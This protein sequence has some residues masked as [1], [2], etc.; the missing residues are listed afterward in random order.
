MQAVK[1]DQ[2][3]ENKCQWRSRKGPGLLSVGAGPRRRLGLPD[4]RGISETRAAEEKE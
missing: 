1:S 3:E 4:C 2:G